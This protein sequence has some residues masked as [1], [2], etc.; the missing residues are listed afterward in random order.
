MSH[1]STTLEDAYGKTVVFLN[2]VRLN[3]IQENTA[4]FTYINIR[5]YISR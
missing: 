5:P 1:L 2:N 4:G 3:W